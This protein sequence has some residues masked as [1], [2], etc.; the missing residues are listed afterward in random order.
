[1]LQWYVFLI[2]NDIT[3]L[4]ALKYAELLYVYPVVQSFQQ[5]T[6]LFDS[7]VIPDYLNKEAFSVHINDK[8]L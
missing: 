7:L 8:G 5:K 2:Y 4:H 3:Y 6:L 1:M